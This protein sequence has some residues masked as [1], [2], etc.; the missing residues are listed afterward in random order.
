MLPSF[1]K[2][3]WITALTSPYP[4]KGAAATGPIVA[5][6]WSSVDY[7]EEYG[8]DNDDLDDLDDDDD[9][10]AHDHD[11]QDHDDNDDDHGDKDYQSIWAAVW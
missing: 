8:N 1:K 4:T 2:S 11:A 6:L 10:D 9:L 5:N 3:F 7:N